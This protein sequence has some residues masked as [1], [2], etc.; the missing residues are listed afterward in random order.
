MYHGDI[1]IE[2]VYHYE[3]A[4]IIKNATITDKPPRVCVGRKE[5]LHIIQKPLT[6][7][8]IYRQHE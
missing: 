6:A 8:S 1:N 5:T 3:L 7:D 4:G 2:H